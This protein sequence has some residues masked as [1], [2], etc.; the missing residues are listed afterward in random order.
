MDRETQAAKAQA[1]RALHH[2]PKLLVLPNI[3]DPLGARLLEGLGYPAVATAS[4]AVAF[5]LGYDDGQRI[6]LEAMLDV[7]HRIAASVSVPVTADIEA[8]YA[9]EPEEVAENVRGA[10]RAGAVGINMEDGWFD[11]DGP[12][13]TV[14]RQA[15]RIRAVR[16]MATEEGIPLVINARTDVFSKRVSG[17]QEDRIAETIER[18][19]AYVEAGADCLYPMMLDDLDALAVLRE[20]VG[21]PLNVLA[22]T[23]TPPMR[24]LEAAGVSRLSLGPGLLKASVTTLRDIARELL[25]YGSYA[26]FT[27][28]AMSSTQIRKFLSKERMP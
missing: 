21:A 20:R 4:A 14:E 24:E 16:A 9:V 18:G 28:E 13:H 25:E 2:D 27:D 17:S 22:W 19:Q 12:L 26:R 10:I 7:V 23:S 8:G 5:S 1:F 11:G 15:D 3:W 6:R